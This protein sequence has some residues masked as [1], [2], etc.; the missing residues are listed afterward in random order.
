MSV[1]FHE[2]EFCVMSSPAIWWHSVELSI[3]PSDVTC[4]LM[5]V[6]GSPMWECHRT[7]I[8]K[9]CIRCVI[10]V[11]SIFMHA[12]Y[13][14]YPHVSQQVFRLKLLY[15]DERIRI[16]VCFSFI[17]TFNFQFLYTQHHIF[18]VKVQKVAVLC[19]SRIDRH[20]CG[21]PHGQRKCA[22]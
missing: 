13:W 3:W 2:T 20:W 14:T 9:V 21:Q 17:I 16:P 15:L 12:M 6:C 10:A 8:A 18:V 7:E 19:C 5:A 22:T 1:H 4:H 11:S